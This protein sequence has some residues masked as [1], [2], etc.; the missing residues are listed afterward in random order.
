MKFPTDYNHLFPSP[1]DVQC[2]SQTLN[3]FQA[4]DDDDE[5]DERSCGILRVVRHTFKTHY[6]Y[7]TG[8]VMQHRKIMFVLAGYSRP[9]G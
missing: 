5:S 4:K 8:I 1:I 2:H 9:V 6:E 7:C 3:N